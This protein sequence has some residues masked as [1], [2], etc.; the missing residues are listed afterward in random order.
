MTDHRDPVFR[1]LPL[2]SLGR[3]LRVGWALF[4]QS[5][6]LSVSYA[7]IFALIGVFV[8]VGIEQASIAPLI[9]PLAGGLLLIGPLLLTGFFALADR[10]ALGERTRYSDIVAACRRTSSGVFAVAFLSTL[11]FTVWVVDM[12]ILYGYAV[13]RLPVLPGFAALPL[14]GAVSFLFWRVALAVVLPFVIFAISA[15]S[16]PLLYYRRAALIQAIRLSVSAVLQ[17]LFVCLSWALILVLAIVG[18]ILIFPLILLIFPVLAFASH[19]LYREL[20]PH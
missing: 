9:L 20:F 13:G 12:A 19:A 16:V 10:L 14:S 1:K 5:R 8:L 4:L 11:L 6:Q 7:M 17:N 18:S 3:A 2:N 15:F